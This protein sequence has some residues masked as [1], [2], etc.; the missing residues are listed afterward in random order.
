MSYRD[1]ENRQHMWPRMDVPENIGT[2]VHLQRGQ[3]TMQR[4]QWLYHKFKGDARY[5]HIADG[6]K[7]ASITLAGQMV[8]H[9]T[10]KCGTCIQ[11]GVINEETFYGVWK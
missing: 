5:Q 7:A 3:R 1:G 8:E 9:A 2:C 11:E 10:E 4:H 6:C